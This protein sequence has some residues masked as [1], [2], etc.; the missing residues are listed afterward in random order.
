MKSLATIILPIIL[1]LFCCTAVSAQQSAAE[2]RIYKNIQIEKF[3]IKQGVELATENAD[4]IAQDI[5]K[6]FNKSKKFN[7]VS[8]IAEKNDTTPTTVVNDSDTPTLRLS[9]EIILYKKGSQGGRYLLGP[10]AG[11][12]FATRLVATVRFTDIKTDEIVL[13]QSVDGVVT[14]GFFGGDKEGANNGLSNEI[15]KLAKKNFTE[16]GK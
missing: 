11:Q 7:R 6:A 10:L 1:C 4:K 5:L 2:K 15:V 12:K 16:K 9:G 13:E 8:L 14:G 3:V